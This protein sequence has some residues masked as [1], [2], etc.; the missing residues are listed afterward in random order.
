MWWTFYPIL[1][2]L[3]GF[4]NGIFENVGMKDDQ[5]WVNLTAGFLGNLF[6]SI[7]MNFLTP[8]NKF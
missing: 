3:Q 8:S 5:K 2:S 4:L 1:G 6:T 7:M